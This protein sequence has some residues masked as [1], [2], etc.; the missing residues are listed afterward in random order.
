MFP[1]EVTLR[2]KAIRA[3]ILG[4]GD[5]T[6]IRARASP[7]TNQK[8]MR[9]MVTWEVKGKNLIWSR[10]QPVLLNSSLIYTFAADAKHE[11]KSSMQGTRAG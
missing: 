2:C 6:P 10:D 11:K 9:R 5:Q 1:W 7:E 4:V 8:A 3:R